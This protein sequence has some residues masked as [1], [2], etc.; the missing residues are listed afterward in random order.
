MKKGL[1]VAVVAAALGGS[2]LVYHAY[3]Q[4]GG[5]PPWRLRQGWRPNAEDVSAFASARIAALRAGLAL[6]AEQEALWPPVEAA[7]R[8]AAKNRLERWQK[9]RAERQS[10]TGPVDP[11]ARLRRRSELLDARATETKKIVDAVQPLYEKLD[12]AQKRRFH[13]L[14]RLGMGQRMAH[15]R[16][17]GDRRSGDWRER[18]R[19]PGMDWRRGGRE[20][21]RPDRRFGWRDDDGP[22]FDRHR[23]GRRRG[24]RFDEPEERL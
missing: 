22:R 17:R 18:H 7:L 15:W 24:M 5:E 9:F 20:D 16:D 2:A 12:E 8:E 14:S 11:I 6:N 4:Q 21:E 10:Q 3:A 1:L 13:I 19:G 23:D